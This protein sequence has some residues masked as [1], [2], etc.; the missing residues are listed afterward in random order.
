MNSRLR[1][2]VAVLLCALCASTLLAQSAGTGALAGVVTDPTGA[3]IP[4]VVVT[5]THN[6]TGQSRTVATGADGAYRFN[7]LPPGT[8][9]VRLAATGFK[10]AE[11]P[12]VTVNVTET[13]TLNYSLE[14]G[15]HGLHF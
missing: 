13:P 10:T 9:K 8:Y 7:L 3:V 15:A 14:V 4:N 12:S 5:A 2:V 11:V 6:D 1:L